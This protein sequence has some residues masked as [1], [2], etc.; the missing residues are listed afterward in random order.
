MNSLLSKLK[1]S[2]R[3]K[4]G[5]TSPSNL[6][7]LS[8]S[9]KASDIGQPFQVKHHIHA[10]I[11]HE[12]GRIEGLPQAWIKLLEASNISN[13]EQS[14]N[15]EV[16]IDVLK[17]YTHSI[18]KKTNNKYIATQETINEDIREI[19]NEWEPNK[20]YAKNENRSQDGSLRTFEE[21]FLQTNQA[22]SKPNHHH[23]INEEKEVNKKDN[24]KDVTSNL[25]EIQKKNEA[26][27]NGT[28]DD[29]K[30]S[31]ETS[32]LDSSNNLVP[33]PQMRRRKSPALV[34][35]L[36]EDVMR[37]LQALIN[38]G[39][40]KLRYKLLKRIGIGASGIVHIALDNQTNKNVAIKI[41]DLAQQQKKELIITEIKVMSENK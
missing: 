34:K 15:P 17:Y 13:S 5:T 25:N 22:E 30:A 6:S 18:K 38:P 11:N 1:A 23:L 31:I 21:E 29:N 4:N 37:A 12:T 27:S 40:P 16:V 8:S 24:L 35:M 32:T 20:E 7:S 28:Q 10:N 41:M 33:I 36:E 3:K 9:F 19:E 39:D 2:G 26:F 14:E